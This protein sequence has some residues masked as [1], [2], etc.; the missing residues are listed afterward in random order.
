MFLRSLLLSCVYH[1]L[2]SKCNPIR[3]PPL[4]M[5]V[6]ELYADYI[7]LFHAFCY[8]QSPVISGVYFLTFCMGLW[9]LPFILINKFQHMFNNLTSNSSTMKP[10]PY[11]YFSLSK[12][13]QKSLG[14]DPADRLS[15]QR[16]NRQQWQQ[17]NPFGA[18]QGPHFCRVSSVFYGDRHGKMTVFVWWL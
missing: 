15:H 18:T 8:S 11:F 5:N 10:G 14:T 6:S 13:V 9:Y 17:L 12:W 7:I 2:F 1:S 4:L 3:N 16:R